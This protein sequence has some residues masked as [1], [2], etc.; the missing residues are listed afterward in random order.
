MQEVFFIA[1]NAIDSVK[2][3]HS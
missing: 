3:I 2:Q 1:E